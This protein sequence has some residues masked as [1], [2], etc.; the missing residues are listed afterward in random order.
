M[1]G[2]RRGKYRGRGRTTPKAPSPPAVKPLAAAKANFV[3][4]DLCSKLD[5]QR[6]FGSFAARPVGTAPGTA[7]ISPAD[8]KTAS[9]RTL[10]A[11]SLVHATEGWKF[12]SSALTALLAHN[13]KQ[14]IHYAYYAELRATVSILSSYGLRVRYPQSSYLEKGGSEKLPSWKKDK[15]HTL[16]WRL[17]SDWALTLP[18]EDLFLDSL[19]VHPSVSLRFFKDAISTVSA[20]A[21]LTAWA[22]DLQLDHEHEARNDASYEAG[23]SRENLRF[24]DASDF[25]FVRDLWALV[26]PSAVGLQFEAQLVHWM[27]KST[28]KDEEANELASTAKTGGGARWINRVMTEVE[29]LT[30][31]PTTELETA[32]SISTAPSQVFDFAFAPVLGAKNI[33]SRA[34]FLLRLATLPIGSAFIHE[35]RTLGKT[36]LRDWLHHSGLF[37]PADGISPADVWADFEHLSTLQSPPVPLPKNLLQ[38]TSIALDILKLGRPDAVMAWSVPL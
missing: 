15:T 1:S 4:P 12:L 21:N 31:V 33:V 38:D 30:G 35:P 5:V 13:E 7:L 26:E 25:E 24:M 3:P 8:A 32:L 37:D 20:S 29:R 36:W 16:V 23:Y 11:E 22:R 28:A 2:S 19:R 14:A 17:W 34:F 27:L 18:A 6:G 9:P 10:A